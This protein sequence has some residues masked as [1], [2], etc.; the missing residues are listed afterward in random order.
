VLEE[1]AGAVVYLTAT[2]QGRPLYEQLGFRGIDISTSY[3]GICRMIPSD[4]DARRVDSASPRRVT[5]G[6][7]AALARLDVDVFGADRRRVLDE[8][9]TFADRFVECGDPVSGYAAA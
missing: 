7:I 4:G 6:D 8:L 2:A 5:A 9:V 3:I 1:A